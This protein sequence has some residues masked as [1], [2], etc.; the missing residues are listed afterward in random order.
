MQFGGVWLNPDPLSCA[1]DS[2]CRLTRERMVAGMLPSNSTRV[3]LYVQGAAAL[4][5]TAPV[6]TRYSGGVGG[7]G[8]SLVK[9]KFSADHDPDADSHSHAPCKG[10]QRISLPLPR[11]RGLPAATSTSGLC[12]RGGMGSCTMVMG[13]QHMTSPRPGLGCRV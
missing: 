1:P 5:R 13:R 8:G 11:L 7:G 9:G 12:S 6:L 10:R 3:R 2:C 4:R